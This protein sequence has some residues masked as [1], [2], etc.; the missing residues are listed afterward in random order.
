MRCELLPSEY[1]A[2]R[3]ILEIPQL[4]ARCSPYIEEEGF[5]WEELYAV[6]RAMSSGERLLIRIAHDLWTSGGEVGLC[7]VTRKLDDQMF[8][9]VLEALRMCRGAYPANRSQWLLE[10]A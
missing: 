5:D 7:E 1:R 3:H 6:A 10:A 4:A 2:V 8:H 9:R